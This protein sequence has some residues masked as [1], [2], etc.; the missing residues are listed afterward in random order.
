QRLPEPNNQE[1]LTVIPKRLDASKMFL[2]AMESSLQ[3]IER[4]RKKVGYVHIWSYAG[5]QYQQLLEQELVY[6]R[7]READG[8]VLDL[9]GGWGGAPLTAL[10]LYTAR[11]LS[12]TNISRDGQRYTLNSVWDKPTVLLVNGGSRSSKEILAFGFQQYDIGPVVGSKTPGA[13]MAGRAFLMSDGSLLY[14]AVADVYV[15][16]KFRLE[17]K[18]V[19][20]DV[21]VP[22]SVEYAQ[23]ADPQKERALKVALE[24]ISSR[25]CSG[26]G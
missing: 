1:D 11:N 23:G 8:L 18:G 13:V 20:P 25:T 16:G 22:F 3:V 14:V 4:E 10:N 21:P 26:T 9:R 7:L 24:S 2:E 17:G 19:E 6:G 12:I 5:E 15:N